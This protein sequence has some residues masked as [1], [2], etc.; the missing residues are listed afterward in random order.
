MAEL[1]L[2]CV[3]ECKIAELLI[4]PGLV[5]ASLLVEVCAGSFPQASLNEAARAA[6]ANAGA[7]LQ[8]SLSEVTRRSASRYN[9]AFLRRVTPDGVIAFVVT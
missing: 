4:E 6:D 1:A 9:P 2:V 5:T 8:T 3:G 7:F